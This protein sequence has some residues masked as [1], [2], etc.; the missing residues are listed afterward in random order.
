LRTPWTLSSAMVFGSTVRP[1]AA[2][3]VITPGKSD[4]DIFST[5]MQPPHSLLNMDLQLLTAC[6]RQVAIHGADTFTRRFFLLN[7][8]EKLEAL[9]RP[10]PTLPAQLLALST[11]RN[12]PH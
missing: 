8:N 2:H 5:S 11:P 1:P 9:V 3:C 12:T 7:T 6:S 4:D 10:P